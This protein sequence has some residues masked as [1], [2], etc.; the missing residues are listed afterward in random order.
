[1]KKIISLILA[2]CIVMPLCVCVNAASFSDLSSNHWAY[3]S[4]K[5][6][7]NE[8]TINGYSDGTFKPN[9]SVTRAEFAKMIGKWNVKFNGTYIDINNNH[10]AYDYIM[11]SGLEANEGRIHPDV[12]IKRYDVINLIWK[13]NGSP[14]HTLA[15]GAISSQGTNPDA[16]SW[17][18]TIGLL[19]GDDGINLRLDSSLTRAE[20]ATLIIRSRELVAK[21]QKFNFIDVISDEILKA[22][23]ESLDLLEGSKYVPDKKLSYAE[24]AR[25]AI[26]FGA[27]GNDINFVGNDLLN[28]KGEIFEPLGNKYDHEMFV[29]SSKIWGDDYY[30]LEKFNQPA[31]KQDTISAILYGFTRRGTTPDAIGEI[32]G[33]YSDCINAD[34]TAWENVYLTFANK[35]G[36]KL[37]ASAALGAN[38][39]VSIKEYAAFLVLFNEIAGLGV[40]YTDNGKINAK[41]NTLGSQMP[42][43]YM[44]FKHTIEG[45]PIGVYAL[46][47]NTISAK[48]A[49]KSANMMA[50]TYRGYL[51]EVVSLAEKSTGCTLEATYYPALSYRQNGNVVFAA[52][53]LVKETKDKNQQVSVDKLLSKVIKQPV[54]HTVGESDEFY[55]VFETKGPL[56]DIYL[57]YSGAYAK[58][59]FIK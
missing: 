6:L 56:M 46:K 28:S 34:S 8:G 23:Y 32:N 5:A 47:K 48:N 49:Y 1:M 37:K 57:P 18:Y 53:F 50:V 54:G 39:T 15:P 17:A 44:D 11:W 25:M 52:K 19:K 51:S 12:D 42:E 3:Q 31:T 26:V 40:G 59:I 30:N 36:I 24:V 16:T 43:N 55:V 4:I 21:N 14:R 2:I 7:V 41:I 27:D 38:E 35:N 29:L 20:A 22:T 9:K 33:Y 13:R 10:W 58:A 45:T